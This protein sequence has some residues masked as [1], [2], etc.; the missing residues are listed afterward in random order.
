MCFQI[1][2]DIFDYYDNTKIG[3]PTGNDMLEGKLTLPAIFVLNNSDNTH[4]HD[5]ARKVKEGSA[6]ADEISDFIEFIKANG[7]ISYAY[8]V[9]DKF[10]SEAYDILESYRNETVKNAIRGYVDFVVS[11]DK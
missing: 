5:I 1:R 9:M 7:G 10:R 8:E 11:R 2:D 6:T 4:Y 3:K